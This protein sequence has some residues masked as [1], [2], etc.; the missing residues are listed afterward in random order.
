M[1]DQLT[2]VA[3]PAHEAFQG[4]V[5][6]FHIGIG[7][8]GPDCDL[9]ISL[10][11][12][13]AEELIDAVRDKDVIALI[14]AMCDLLYV[15]YG[16]ADVFSMYLETRDAAKTPPKALD[17]PALTKEMDDFNIAVGDVVACLRLMKMYM[18]SNLVGKE[19]IRAKLKDDLEDLAQGVWECAAEGVGVDLRPFFREVHRTNMHKLKGPKREDGKQLKPPDWKPPRIAAMYNRIQAGNPPVCNNSHD[20][21]LLPHPEGGSFCASCGGLFV[22]VEKNE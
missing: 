9:R 6:D 18:T 20:N 12:E 7:G 16:T 8:Q 19:G 14:D 21:Y 1:E 2:I 15:V 3:I 10:I 17:W 22:Q 13:E 4:M 5:K 11:Q